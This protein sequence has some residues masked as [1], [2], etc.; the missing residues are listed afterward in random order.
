MYTKCYVYV[1]GE[2]LLPPFRG[3]ELKTQMPQ[4]LKKEKSSQRKKRILLPQ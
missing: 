4:L 2:M 1:L 3:I